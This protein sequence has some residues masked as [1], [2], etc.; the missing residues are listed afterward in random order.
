MR[1]IIR[2]IFLNS[3]AKELGAT[4]LE[5]NSQSITIP[6]NMV[7]LNASLFPRFLYFSN[8]IL[9]KKK[10]LRKVVLENR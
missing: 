5:I 8:T 2:F 7:D 6:S 10:K 4:E 3:T 9:N 1:V